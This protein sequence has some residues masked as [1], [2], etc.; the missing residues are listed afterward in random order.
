MAFQLPT[1]DG[2]F[3]TCMVC[4]VAQSLT[5]LAWGSDL[6]DEYECTWSS[7]TGMNVTAALLWIWAGNMIKSFPEALPPSGRGRR[8]PIYDDG[9]YDDDD[10]DPDVHFQ[11]DVDMQADQYDDYEY[12]GYDDGAD[13]YADDNGYPEYGDDQFDD[14]YVDPYAPEDGDPN[15]YAPDD[16]A[17]DD[18][19]LDDD[20][21]YDRK[22]D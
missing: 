20:D 9:E 2:L 22:I 3:W 18:D 14:G 7:G 4:F 17:E 13:A 16:Y 5:F 10:Y 8:K 21:D 19:Y 11:D 6:C 1:F 15:P 12:N